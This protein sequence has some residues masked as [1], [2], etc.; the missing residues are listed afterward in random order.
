VYRCFI[1]TG[2]SSVDSLIGNLVD[3]N[4]QVRECARCSRPQLCTLVH[5]LHNET[6]GYSVRKLL[7]RND[8]GAKSR[9]QN[10]FLHPA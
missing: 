5:K 9:A 6:A 7:V 10:F 8:L 1:K 3:S 4:L 2:A